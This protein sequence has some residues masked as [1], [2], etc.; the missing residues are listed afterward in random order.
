MGS[1]IGKDFLYKKIK[2]ILTFNEIVLLKDYCILKHKTNQKNF[3][4]FQNNNGDSMFYG[5]ALMTTLLQQKTILMEY[6]CGKSL[7]PTY[8]FWRMYSKYAELLPHTDR[9][10][11]EISVTI[12]IGSSGETWP[13][14]MDGD[15]IELEPGDGA[16]YMGCKIKHWR[17][18]FKGDWSSQVFLHYVDKN[19]PFSEYKWDKKIFLGALTK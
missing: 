8:A 5:D 12:N 2:G 9:P 11:C 10:S 15:P 13:I 4:N 6:H 17:E 3:D 7:W 16:I 18:E 1:I 19:G 14:F